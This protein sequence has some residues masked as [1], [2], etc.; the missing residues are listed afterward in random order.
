M[1]RERIENLIIKFNNGKLSAEEQRALELLIESGQVDIESLSIGV[2]DKKI[3]ELSYPTPTEDLDDRFYQ[4]L[5]LQ[6]REIKSSFSWKNFFSWNQLSPKLAFASIALVLG[7][8][9]GYII[10][11]NEK[12]GTEIQALSQQVNDLK[13]MMMLSLLEKESATERLRA[14]SLT[15]EMSEASAKVTNALLKTLNS[16]DNVNV[17]LAALEALLP[18]IKESSVREELIRSIAK[19]ESPLVQVALAEL[20]A[21]IQ[22]KSSVKELEKIIQSERTPDEVKNRI[23]ES[24]KILS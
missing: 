1:E 21:Q 24:I 2:L 6:K 16:D 3:T 12:P 15:S 11:P 9:I 20:M 22:E 4:M 19:Q 23:K 18:Y 8:G 13:E 10:K 5:A 14:V 7:M 17:R